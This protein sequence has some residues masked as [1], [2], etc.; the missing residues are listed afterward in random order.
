MLQLVK[1][2]WKDEDGMGTIEIVVIIAVLMA[3]ALLFRE[4]IGKFANDLM[5][6]LFQ[7]PEVPN[8]P[9]TPEG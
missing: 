3:L 6:S 4:G 8:I 9:R 7:S 1:G 2:F 5:N